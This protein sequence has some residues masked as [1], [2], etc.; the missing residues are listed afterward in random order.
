MNHK[1]D[2]DQWYMARLRI[3]RLLD[4]LH[5]AQYV[6]FPRHRSTSIL[7]RPNLLLLSLRK[8]TFQGTQPLSQS[9]LA[10]G[11]KTIAFFF[12]ND[13]HTVAFAAGYRIDLDGI[14]DVGEGDD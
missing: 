9:V 13:L 1:L 3:N 4:M 12:G 11:T 7:L 10:A 14:D 6:Q 5:R 8:L 2:F